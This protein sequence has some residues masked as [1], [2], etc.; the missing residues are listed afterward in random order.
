MVSFKLCAVSNIVNLTMCTVGDVEHI[1]TKLS[2]VLGFH[3]AAPDSAGRALSVLATIAGSA[4]EGSFPLD[5]GRY[6]SLIVSVSDSRLGKN[7]LPGTRHD[8][9]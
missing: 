1:A 6:G 5:F 2:G 4:I 8:L 7:T 3:L 9:A